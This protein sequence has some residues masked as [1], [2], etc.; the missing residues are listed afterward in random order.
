MSSGASI[1]ICNGTAGTQISLEQMNAETAAVRNEQRIIDAINVPIRKPGDLRYSRKKTEGYLLN[2]NHPKG[3][4]KAIFMEEVLGY[5]QSDSRRFH[6]AVIE[7]ILGKTPIKTQQTDFGLKHTF[8]TSIKG[9][10]GTSTK[11]NVVVIIQKDK[12]RITYKIVTVY[13]DRKDE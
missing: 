3:K 2:K 7:S 11:A 13:P 9:K 5:T 10:N 12:H 1:R 8:K 6:K 4:S